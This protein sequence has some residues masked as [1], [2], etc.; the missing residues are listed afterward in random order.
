MSKEIYGF[1]GVDDEFYDIRHMHYEVGRISETWLVE[2]ELMFDMKKG[3]RYYER[4]EDIQGSYTK[5]LY[6]KILG[7]VIKCYSGGFVTNK[8]E[9][10]DDYIV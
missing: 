6:V 8:L 9:V 10:L 3:F 7:P 5:V 4:P 1:I 2:H